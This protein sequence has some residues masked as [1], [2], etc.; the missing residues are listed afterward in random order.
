MIS[1]DNTSA[2]DSGTVA[3]YCIVVAVWATTP[4]A[5]KWSGEALPPLLAAGSRMFLAVCI[6]G[7]WLLWRRQRLPCDRLALKSY[8]AAVPGIFGAMACSY[9][10]A[11]YLPSGLIS[12]IFGLA[13]LL[14]GL[15]MQ[16][17]RGAHHFT[18]WHWLGCLMGLSGLA[19]IFSDSLRLLWHSQ[20]L[21][22][23]GVGLLWLL[24]AVTLF[25]ASGI[26][27][28]QVG[29]GLKPM[30]QTM[31]G[32]LLSLPFYGLAIFW[33]VDVWQFDSSNTRGLLAI[34]YLSIMG[35]LV[36]FYSY[37]HVLSRLPAATVALVTLMTPV[38]ALL[39]GWAVNQE[40]LA[41]H[42]LQGSVLILI[43]LGIYLLGDRRVRQALV[44]N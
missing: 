12:V 3:A 22:L 41:P 38:L 39:L 16:C 29:A 10:G 9:Q 44:R 5:I 34:V 36:G 27:V 43:S 21:G 8:L 1:S 7:L 26:A 37:F 15:M 30:Q 11:Q 13:P 6:G 14:S 2:W 24:A 40:Q 28:K 23:H 42:M 20:Q 19:W 31:G 4:L 25:A 35:S 18:A 32:L 33:S 17:Q